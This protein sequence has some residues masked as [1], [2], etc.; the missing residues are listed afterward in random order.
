M[1]HF[2]NLGYY[3]DLVDAAFA[4]GPLFPTTHVS[5]QTVREVLRF[6]LG[7]E[8]PAVVRSVRS[9]KCDGI[10]GEELSWTVGFG[11]R[12]HAFI[13]KPANAHTPL[14]GIVALYDHGHFKFF[15]K[16]KVA[17]GPEGPLASIQP[18]RDT[19]YGGRAFANEL[20]REGFVVLIHDTFLWGSRKLPL[21]NMP[22]ADLSLA[23]PAGSALGHGMIDEQVL[24]IMARPTSTKTRLRN[25]A[26][27]SAPTSRQLLRTKIE[28]R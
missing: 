7:D 14:P 9:W 25:I 28:L 22:E 20:A 12:T 17:D 8:Q 19:Y 27:C 2:T 11:P 4:Q 24:R 1:P 26:L 6:T 16:E 15:G 23:D 3:S 10:D 21:E 13:L 18:F 5:V